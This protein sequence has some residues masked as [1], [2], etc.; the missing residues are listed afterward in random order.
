[1][2]GFTGKGGKAKGS[3]GGKGSKAKGASNEAQGGKVSGVDMFLQTM[4]AASIF[5]CSQCVL[6]APA[7]CSW[8]P[9]IEVCLL[10]VVLPKGI[11]VGCCK[12]GAENYQRGEKKTVPNL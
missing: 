7:G 12:H 10:S 3:G 11:G 9:Y 4:V 5:N 6:P 2:S 1:M 8:Q